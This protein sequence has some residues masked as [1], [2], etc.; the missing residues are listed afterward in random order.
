MDAEL[1][2][3]LDA[4]RQELSEQIAESRQHAEQLNQDTRR[5]LMA[6]AEQ[7]NQAT[8]QDLMAH[9][10]R[11]NQ[12][13]RQDLTQQIRET[14]VLVEDLRQDLKAVAEGVLTLNDKVDR[15]MADHEARIARL[16]RRLP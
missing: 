5:D 3:Y 1:K 7:L 8:R 14:R 15:L 4:L 10:E 9:A 13:T 2:A 11:L 12:E 16:E 6:H